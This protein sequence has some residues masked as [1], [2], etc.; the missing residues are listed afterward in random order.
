VMLRRLTG[1]ISS[2]NGSRPKGDIQKGPGRPP[3]I[4]EDFARQ[5]A[6]ASTLQAAYGS[7]RSMNSATSRRW[8]L[9]SESSRKDWQASLTVG[10][11]SISW[12]KT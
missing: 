11:S 6:H 9:S 7:N 8:I 4:L 12:P 5:N 3:I 1:T 10:T 2:G